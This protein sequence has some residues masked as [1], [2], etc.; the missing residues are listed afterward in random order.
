MGR[1]TLATVL[2]WLGQHGPWL[3]L[4]LVPL[5]FVFHSVAK[6]SAAWQAQYLATDT[7]QV[8]LV[9]RE[10]ELSHLWDD[11]GILPAPQFAERQFS[12]QFSTCVT[13][14]QAQEVALML[15]ARGQAELQINQKPILTLDETNERLTRGT[16]LSLAKGT[17][18]LRVNYASDGKFPSVALLASFDGAPPKPLASGTLV[19]GVKTLLPNTEGTACE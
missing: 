2:S 12:A 15:V 3:S 18:H 14:A 1:P 19:N 13:L 9:Q 11:K 16:K 8:F 5:W 6:P 17:H 10:Q 4:A 7:A